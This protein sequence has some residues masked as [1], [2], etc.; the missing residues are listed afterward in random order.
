M[1]TYIQTQAH[2]PPAALGRKNSFFG[3]IKNIVTAPLSWFGGSEEDFDDGDARGKRRR[4][5]I[6]SEQ[7][8]DDSDSDSEQRTKR[9]RMGSPNRD[10]QPYLDPPRSA[11]RQ[12]H[13]T[14]EDV[15]IQNHRHVSPSPRKAL[16]VPTTTPRNRR[17][18][19]PY[20]SGSQLKAQPSVRTMS[21]DPP[22][23]LGYFG[24]PARLQ[25]V[26]TM[27]DLTEEKD[28]M[29]ISREPSMSNLRMRTSVTP[30]PSGSDF[31]PV[32]P[33]RRERDPTEPPP[34]TTLMSNPM[35]V[36]PPP[37]LQKS[38]TAEMTRQATLGSLLDSQRKQTRSP[39]RRGSVLFGTGSMTDISAPHLWP[40]NP[41]EKALHELEVYK[42]PLLPSRL[43]GAPI[44]DTFISKKSRPITLM[45]DRDRE[46]KKG[47]GKNKMKDRDGVNGTKPYAGEGGMKKWLARRRREEEAVR[48]YEEADREKDKERAMEE[49]ESAELRLK[50]QC[51]KQMEVAA[52]PKA[53]AFEPKLSTTR[54][55]SSLRVGRSRM[56]NHIERPSAKRTNKFSAAFEDDEDVMDDERA[57]LEEAAKKVPVFEIPAG[58]TF[59][60]ETSIPHDATGTKEP[61]ISALPFS[62]SKPIAPAAK[63]VSAPEPSAAPAPA[64]PTISFV[65]PTPQPPKS[66][67]R[68]EAAPV[69]ATLSTSASN[70]PNF[71]S[72]TAAY[73]KPL[74]VTTLSGSFGAPPPVLA[75]TPALAQVPEAPKVTEAS[76]SL[77][78]TPITALQVPGTPSA[79]P[80]ANSM[81]G[82]A[83]VSASTSIFGPSSTST[84]TS[85]GVLAP[86]KAAPAAI[87]VTPVASPVISPPPAHASTPAPSSSPSL[88]SASTA[89]AEVAP[90]N[91]AP[92]P[93]EQ[94]ASKPPSLFPSH[95]SLDS[96][97]GNERRR[98]AM[99]EPSK[100]AFSFGGPAPS[101]T[102]APVPAPVIEAPKPFFGKQ[103][104]TS[105][106]G[107]SF[108]PRPS[109]APAEEKPTS[110]LPPFS[111]ASASPAPAEKKPF[112]FGT[113]SPAP[114]TAT[115][116][117][118]SFGH[119]NAGSNTADTSKP[120]NFGQSAPAPAPARPATPPKVDQ[121]I[122]MDESP[123]RDMNTNGKAP[124]RLTLD[125][126]SFSG[127]SSTPAGSTLFAQSPATATGPGFGFNTASANPFAKPEDKEKPGMAFGSGSFGQPS[128]SGFGFGQG[129][130][131]TPA[132]ASAAPFSFSQAASPNVAPTPGFGF[133]Q[134]ASNAFGQQQST[135]SAPSSPSAFNR[136][137]TSFSFGTPASTQPAAPSFA[138]GGSQP[139]SPATSAGGLPQPSG[140][141]FAFGQ[142][143]A[144]PAATPNSFAPTTASSGGGALFTIGAAPQPDGRQIK[145][146]PRRGVGRR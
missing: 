101:T 107:F 43:K 42:T 10:K 128:G 67:E 134:T 19:S 51:K 108:G 13:R 79:V 100:S 105:A 75:P 71:F 72:N 17:T 49:D 77:F 37:G 82:A 94:E 56:R 129:A 73:T 97:S 119:A 22:S 36:K 46:R 98:P 30:Q 90:A 78:G 92:K 47:K 55:M 3:A 127:A 80:V 116:K 112:T 117:P 137:G 70:I 61:P 25:P 124:E 140:G 95:P 114:P 125:F 1:S 135:S 85:F 59:A 58:F 136:P 20:P 132:P 6:A 16:R 109:T 120:F 138:F 63:P 144:A 118:F 39:V 5:P 99:T 9:M 93:A 65:P 102:L 126:S 88:F 115:A 57:A 139:A 53:P 142:S 14:S 141:G 54:E 26:P 28:A 21:L 81:F 103:D 50:A 123:S 2:P 111:F 52:L 110:V 38:S 66:E 45:H 146:L 62:L 8:R 133:S 131:E 32:I 68:T 121:E 89:P 60:K 84:G 35:F 145:K 33:P 15:R 31:G 24:S 44:P 40:I 69:T 74:A 87:E 48:A 41:A 96:L 104:T 106:A 11:F 29:S 12:H 86:P 143:G 83:P 76:T 130:T 91:E 34:L 7:T 27:Q 122:S 23:G 4:L 64:V 18:M 113:P